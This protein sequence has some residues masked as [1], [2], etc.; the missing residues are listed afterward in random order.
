MSIVSTALDRFLRTDPIDGGSQV[1]DSRL[2]EQQTGP[3]ERSAREDGPG[4]RRGRR[5]SADRAYRSRDARPTGR[6]RA[7]HEQPANVRRCRDSDAHPAGGR[8]TRRCCVGVA[9]LEQ[10]AARHP[11]FPFLD[12]AVLHARAVL[13]SDADTALLAVARSNGDPRS[14]VV[15]S[16]LEDAGRLLPESR[17]PEAVPLLESSLELYAAAG[18]QRDASRVHSLL[19]I[20]GV[21]PAARGLRSAPQWPELTESEFAVVS[22]SLEEQRTVR[23]PSDSS[24][25]RR[26]STPTCGTCSESWGS[27]RASS[28]RASRPNAASPPDSLEREPVLRGPAQFRPAVANNGSLMMATKPG[29]DCGKQ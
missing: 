21:R 29:E 4:G 7:Q 17:T 20:R 9:N 2:A 15:A 12:C 22:L 25:R 1:E 28:W 13:D 14:L 24:C 11:D 19:R 6:W 10:F 23:S 26:R 5:S 3:D 8:Q 18:A 27:A 16:V